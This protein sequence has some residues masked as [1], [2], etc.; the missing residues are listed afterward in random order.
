[1]YLF[2]N[3]LHILA[4][5]SWISSSSS[6]SLYLIYKTFVLKDEN[7]EKERK[8]LQIFSILRSIFVFGSNIPWIKLILLFYDDFQ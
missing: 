4:V 1:M 2:L 5:I 6:M 8:I 3:Y 7:Q